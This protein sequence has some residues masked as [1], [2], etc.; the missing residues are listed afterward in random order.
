[1]YTEKKFPVP[2][3]A[4]IAYRNRFDGKNNVYK[5]DYVQIGLQVFF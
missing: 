5:S 3:T 2:L 1:L 4:N